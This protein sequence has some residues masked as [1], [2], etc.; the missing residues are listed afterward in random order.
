MVYYIKVINTLIKKTQSGFDRFLHIVGGLIALIVGIFLFENPAPQVIGVIFGIW[1]LVEGIIG[2][3]V[4]YERFGI[5]KASDRL[6]GASIFLLGL[7]WVQYV[8]SYVWFKSGYGKLTGDFAET[9]GSTLDRFVEANP[10]PWFVSYLDWVS[11][12]TDVLAQ[13]IQ[14][15]ELLTGVGLAVAATI[16]IFF[17]QRAVQMWGMIIAII[18]LVGSLALNFNFYFAA[19]HL[20]SSTA[21]INLVMF[22]IAL[23]LLYVWVMALF[24]KPKWPVVK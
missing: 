12:W 22:W 1:L 19:G 15:G 16:L 3:C 4:L 7:A 9:L 10:W 8:L 18:S 11:Q 24:H 21:S 5:N 14:W 2:R 17:K 13:F 20:S 6:S 23:G